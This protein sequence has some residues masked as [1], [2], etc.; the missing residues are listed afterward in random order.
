MM[1]A[2]TPQIGRAG[3]AAPLR[4]AAARPAAPAAPAAPAR[5]RRAAAAAAPRPHL[6]PCRAAPTRGSAPPPPPPARDTDTNA[7]GSAG[8][9][10]LW[11]ALGAY[12]FALAPNQTPMRDQYFLEKLLNLT[13]D[14]VRLNA[15]F[16][17]LFFAMGVWPLVYTALLIPAARSANKVPAWPFVFGSYGVGAFALLPFM[18]LW[19]APAPAPELPPTEAELAGPGN[20]LAR[21]MESPLLAWGLLAGATACVAQAA[22]AGPASWYE[23]SKLVQESRFVHVTTLD[24]LTLT[25]LAPFWMAN[26]AAARRWEGA[27]RLLLPL[28]LVPVLGPC[29]YLVLRPKGPR[30]E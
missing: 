21:G 4:L 29:V 8:I 3:A 5:R 10:L 2:C 18:A 17:Q 9:F 22:A 28:S 6:A 14:P 25:T 12:A 20:L 26:D 11:A 1:R 30:A 27:G 7:I 23:Y 15:V 19:Q 24:F 16:T 13:T